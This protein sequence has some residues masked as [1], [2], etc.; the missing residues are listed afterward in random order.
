MRKLEPIRSRA[1]I[2]LLTLGIACSSPLITMAKEGKPA[3]T[4]TTFEDDKKGNKKTRSL[5]KVNVK[6][7]PHFYK[8]AMSIVAKSDANRDMTFFVFDIE[9]NL[10]MNYK[11]KSGEHMMISDL[12]KGSYLYTVFFDDEQ[13]ASGK[14]LFR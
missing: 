4:F 11:V 10:I 13:V 14:L 3:R 6:V 7:Y 1:T 5:S 2:L 12:A 8:R 9:G